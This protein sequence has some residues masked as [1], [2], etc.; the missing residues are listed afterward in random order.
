MR[1]PGKEPLQITTGDVVELHKTIEAE[2][3]AHAAE[4]AG[5]RAALK[6]H[7]HTDACRNYAAEKRHAYCITECRDSYESVLT[8]DPGPLVAAVEGLVVLL[9]RAA[10]LLSMVYPKYPGDPSPDNIGEF[11]VA[12]TLIS[13]IESAL[14]DYRAAL[15]GTN[16]HR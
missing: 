11:V 16:G 9:D 3:L 8:A 7:K 1:D 2:R 6:N 14:A 13:Q 15:G 5:L 10:K 4:V 12:H